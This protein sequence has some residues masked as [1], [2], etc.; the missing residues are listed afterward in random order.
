MIADQGPL[1]RPDTIPDA[2]SA[3]QRAASLRE[4]AKQR[5][6]AGDHEEA[7]WARGLACGWDNWAVWAERERGA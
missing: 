6:Q 1:S 4:Y 7:T 2:Q 3:R 5:D